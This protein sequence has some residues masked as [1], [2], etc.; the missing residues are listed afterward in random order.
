VINRQIHWGVLSLGLGIFILGA[1]QA[2]PPIVPTEQSTTP[3]VEAQAT[4]TQISALSSPLNSPVPTPQPTPTISKP[5]AGQAAIR[6]ALSSN[7][8]Q[9][10]IGETLF[11]LTPGL[12]EQGDLFPPLL[13]GPQENDIQGYTDKQG[14]FTLSNVPPGTYYLI[15]WAPLSWT[16]LSYIDGASVGEPILLDL[17]P[18]Q[19]L[20]LGEIITRWP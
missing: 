19:T 11:Y 4:A 17:Q 6:G 8:T 3:T 18:D 7:I 1:C 15:I 5:A 16:P 2:Q 20:D 14:W 12:G 13:A 10:P 9:R